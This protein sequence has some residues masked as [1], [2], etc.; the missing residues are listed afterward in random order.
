[1]SGFALIPEAAAALMPMVFWGSVSAVVYAYAAYPALVYGLSR[2]VGEE[3][4]PPAIDRSRLPRVALLIAA[5]NERSVID[6]RIRNAFELDYP[7]DRLDIVVASDGSND[8]TVDLCRNHQPRVRVLDFPIRR[9]K[10]ATLNAAL[11]TI[12]AEIVVLSDA[13]TMMG[14]EALVRLVR[15]FERPEVGAVCGR[16]VLREFG[17]GRNADGAYWRY[18]TFL[19][20]CEGRLGGLLG[21]NGAIYAIRRSLVQP[22]PAGTVVDDFV[23]PLL[24]KIVSDCTIVY[25]PEAMAFEETAPSVGG[26][27][28]RRARIGVGGFQALWILRRL[29]NP[30]RGW[31]SF[32]FWSHKVLRWLCP[33]CMLA[34]LCSSAALAGQ[35]LYAAALLFQVLLYSTAGL[36]AALPASWQ[37][38]RKLRILP[39]FVWM[40]V[41]LLVGFFRFLRGGHGGVWKR[42]A[43][44][45]DLKRV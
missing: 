13:N 31:T 19:K 24:A 18:E 22:L 40:N 43:R 29:L 10:S 26:E 1:M 3:S 30:L 17:S 45:H 41:A 25:D 4:I 34:A 5:H 15:W 6:E 20:R 27:F 21:A 37:L 8:G 44:G 23:L 16:L 32:T 42:T 11:E 2:A 33:F 35:P 38:T 12:D 36:A 39:M 9:G 14:R 7:S 28:R